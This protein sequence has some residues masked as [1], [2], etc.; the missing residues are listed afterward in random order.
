[1]AAYSQSWLNAEN[2]CYDYLL[3]LLGATNGQ[4]AFLGGMP[5]GLLNAWSFGFNG[6]P[7]SILAR[8]PGAYTPCSWE[9]DAEWTAAYGKRADA[10]NAIGILMDALPAGANHGT[11]TI[12]Y[13]QTLQV[14][15]PPNI[16]SEWVEIANSNQQHQITMVTWQLKVVFKLNA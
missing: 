7:E 5:A 12:P 1:M 11:R 6:G 15:R 9:M 2:A 16:A 10:I 3:N 13:V 8:A 14:V 4:N